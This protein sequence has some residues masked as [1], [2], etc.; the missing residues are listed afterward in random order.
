MFRKS[1]YSADIQKLSKELLK[2]VEKI[3]QVGG[4]KL[5]NT[6]IEE[7]RL[8][9]KSRYRYTLLPKLLSC[10]KNIHSSLK[11]KRHLINYYLK[12]RRKERLERRSYSRGKKHGLAN[13]YLHVDYFIRKMYMELG[14]VMYFSLLNE[15]F[16]A[17]K[18]KWT[19]IKNGLIEIFER[20]NPRFRLLAK[21][22][23]IRSSFKHLLGVITAA[24]I[25]VMGIVPQMV[26]ESLLNPEYLG[27]S[28]VYGIMLMVVSLLTSA[29]TILYTDAN[30]NNNSEIT[31]ESQIVVCSQLHA[32]GYDLLREIMMSL[33]LVLPDDYQVNHVEDLIPLAHK[34]N[35]SIRDKEELSRILL[36]IIQNLNESGL[37]SQ[38]LECF[39][40]IEGFGGLIKKANSIEKVSIRIK[41]YIS[42]VIKDAVDNAAGDLFKAPSE[43]KL[44]EFVK[45][46]KELI[47]EPDKFT[48]PGGENLP[49]IIEMLALL[50]S[51]YILIEADVNDGSTQFKLA[52]DAKAYLKKYSE[53]KISTI[54]S[55]IS[56]YLKYY[57]LFVEKAEDKNIRSGE[58]QNVVV[59]IANT[60]KAN[61]NY[62]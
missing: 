38:T 57:R 32:Y 42:K 46:G 44:Q 22:I 9:E 20:V 54:E 56:S 16:N 29:L 41:Y 50:T 36:G 55:F 31:E 11:L 5:T 14:Q 60:Y 2:I 47:I 18:P 17:L 49:G 62:L 8:K 15:L 21:K 7:L 6:N 37:A 28:I 34:L 61:T 59:D 58:K 33:T 39:R 45:S 23:A 27:A 52:F 30:E 43:I 10:A 26:R 1:Y 25:E 48:K 3:E 51:H 53:V 19:A 13:N 24:F 40:L 4:D 12:N 35:D